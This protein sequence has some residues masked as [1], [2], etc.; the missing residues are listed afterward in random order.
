MTSGNLCPLCIE[1]HRGA[2]ACPACPIRYTPQTDEPIDQFEG[3]P[4]GEVI[5]LP[6][7]EAPH[8]SEAGGGRSGAKR[9]G[10]QKKQ[11]FGLATS[12]SIRA[13]DHGSFAVAP[14]PGAAPHPT[15]ADG[16]VQGEEETDF[17]VEMSKSDLERLL[18][19]EPWDEE[20][21]ED[22][23]PASRARRGNP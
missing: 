21:D 22:E 20:S 16:A 23:K 18:R 7:D 10:R 3:E 13:E 6:M 15:A 11:P 17:T 14:E 12:E 9:G 5:A 2:C 8:S 19:A 1:V 4:T